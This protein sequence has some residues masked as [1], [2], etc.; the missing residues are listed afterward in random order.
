[1][2]VLLPII[3]GGE[4]LIFFHNLN[5][6]SYWRY[7]TQIATQVLLGFLEFRDCEEFVARLSIYQN[8]VFLQNKDPPAHIAQ[9]TKNKIHELL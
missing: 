7:A 2:R 8:I 4:K 6:D 5:K 1:M 3:I 9:L